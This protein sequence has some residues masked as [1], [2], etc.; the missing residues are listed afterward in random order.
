MA[1]F[2]NRVRVKGGEKICVVPS[3]L[4]FEA[5]GGKKKKKKKFVQRRGEKKKWSGLPP[6]ALVAPTRGKK[7]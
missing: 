3:G 5:K 7:N 2:V 4:S 6:S 1:S